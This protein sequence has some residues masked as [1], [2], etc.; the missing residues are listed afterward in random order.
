MTEVKK[1]T[2]NT[3]PEELIIKDNADLKKKLNERI[4]KIESGEAKMFTIDEAFKEIDK[5]I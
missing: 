2:E 5:I 3:I 4:K 1:Y